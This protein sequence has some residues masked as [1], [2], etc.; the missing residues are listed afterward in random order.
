MERE[1]PQR[2]EQEQR[3]RE[4]VLES[5]R[6]MRHGRKKLDDVRIK[7][8]GAALGQA[9]TQGQSLKTIRSINSI[10]VVIQN[11]T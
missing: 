2:E 6:A 5:L 9:V 1:R 7:E 8:V 10:Q 3:M 11:M 4:R